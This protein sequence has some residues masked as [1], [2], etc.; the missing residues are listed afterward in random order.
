VIITLTDKGNIPP[1]VKSLLN[2]YPALCVLAIAPDGSQ[3]KVNQIGFQE[4]FVL[5]NLSL[6]ELIAILRSK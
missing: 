1:P 2:R 6:D 4:D 3:V 5:D